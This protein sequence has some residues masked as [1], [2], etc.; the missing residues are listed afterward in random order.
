MS[1]KLQIVIILA[2]NRKKTKGMPSSTGSYKTKEM[3]ALARL[4]FHQLYSFFTMPDSYYILSLPCQILTIFRRMTA[5]LSKVTTTRSNR[6]KT[7]AGKRLE[8]LVVANSTS[9]MRM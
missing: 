7:M 2:E 3:G 8:R 1:K 6:P 5:M 4:P 9:T